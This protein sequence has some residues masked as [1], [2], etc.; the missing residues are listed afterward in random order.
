MLVQLKKKEPQNV[1]FEESGD[2][3]EK[4]VNVTVGVLKKRFL[5]SLFEKRETHTYVHYM[6][7]EGCTR[8]VLCGKVKGALELSNPPAWTLTHQR[9]AQSQKKRKPLT[10][11]DRDMAAFLGMFEDKDMECLFG[12][13]PEALK[14][15]LR[16]G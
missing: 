14:L 1:A 11:D 2:S 7:L 9:L 13:T 5:F 10:F 6:P 3:T 16:K 4:L 12:G 15:S 8:T